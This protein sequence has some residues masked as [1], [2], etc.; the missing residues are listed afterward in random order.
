[1]GELSMGELSMGEPPVHVIPYMEVEGRGKRPLRFCHT[2][3][4]GHTSGEQ[5]AYQ[6]LC[7]QARKHGRAETSGASLLD[8][9]L[10]QLCLLLGADHKNVK[11]LLGSL[12]EK[13]AIEVVRQPDYRLAIP[14]RYRIFTPNQILERRRS[15]GLMWVI[16]TRTIRFVELDTVRRLIAEQSEGDQP[17]G[18]SPES[19]VG[20]SPLATGPT[21]ALG[22]LTAAL[23]QWIAI[24]DSAVRQL[25]EACRRGAPDC[26]EDEVAWFCRSKQALIHSGR[27]DHPVGLLLRS[28]PP[29]FANGGSLALEEHRK[30]RARDQERERRRER[31]VA[32]MVIDNPESDA[33]ELAWAR[34]ILGKGQGTAP[35]RRP[36][37]R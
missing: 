24:D 20:D 37:P 22:S 19:P 12:Q 29:F 32:Q 10:S 25:W 18:H 3:Q 26:T 1:M 21:P 27:I 17:T 6:A 16:R 30:E 13:L 4:D 31:Q 2:A 14:T 9:G 34:E 5:L 11:R 8:I 28:I 33:A 23:N 7:N 15:A 35:P 36:G